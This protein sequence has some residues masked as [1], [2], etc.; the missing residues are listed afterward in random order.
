MTDETLL[1][2]ARIVAEAMARVPGLELLE[3]EIMVSG[4]AAARAVDDGD[5]A[6]AEALGRTIDVGLWGIVE[7]LWE[8][9]AVREL[10]TTDDVKSW[11]VA[12]F[13]R[14]SPDLA[15]HLPEAPLTFRRSPDAPRRLDA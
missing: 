12:Y 6:L 3:Q 2:A 9:P 7:A 1:K 15:R 10:G 4:G 14:R 8:D 11:T 5:E 13:R